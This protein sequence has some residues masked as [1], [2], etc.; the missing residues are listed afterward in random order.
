MVGHHAH[1]R[2]ARVEHALYPLR[3]ALELVFEMTSELGA[4]LVAERVE[5]AGLQPPV[6]GMGAGSVGAAAGEDL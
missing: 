3:H 5:L 6:R 2:P 1:R 4:A